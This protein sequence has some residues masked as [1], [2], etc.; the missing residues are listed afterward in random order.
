MN[1]QIIKNQAIGE[2]YI[3]ITH[4]TGLSIYL[5]Q[6]EGFSTTYAMFSTNY[7]SIDTKFKLCTDNEIHTVP[8]GIA[9]F[10]EHKLF[11]SEE[12]DVFM[13]FA[14]TGASANAF[15]SFEIT[16]YLFATT[17]NFNE[18]LEILLDFVQ[19]PYFTKESVEKEQGIIA[20]EIK[21]Y[22]DDPHWR[23]EFN[24]LRSMYFNHTVKE[25]VAGTVESISKITP[26][27]LYQCYKTFYNLNNMSL[28]IVGNFDINEVKSIIDNS[29]KP[30]EKVEINRYFENE[31][32]GVVNS[33]TQEE[34]PVSTPLFYFGY[35]ENILGTKND[36]EVAATEILLDIISSPS[37]PLYKK[38]YDMEL[39]ND[40]SFGCD[41]LEGEGYSAVLFE[42]ES[43]DSLKV[44]EEIK[45]YVS[46]L[47]KTG[48]DED[49]FRRAKKS[50][51]G[52]NISGL[53]S[54]SS[55][56]Y[57]ITSLSFK[58]RELYNYLSSF[59]DITLSDVE[60]RLHDIFKD[61][62]YVLSVINPQNEE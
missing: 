17:E 31:P 4:Q 2:E 42:G 9:H 3:K 49:D 35:K 39:I 48:I 54:V 32:D 46:K 59:A 60:K 16:S 34:L 21:M 57:T 38:L 22:D 10:L 50:I 28:T 5:Y 20:Q 1:E 13:K 62:N 43:K 36:K 56:A 19:S 30:C 8:S 47:K 33:F 52:T 18:S 29:L 55:I 6:K 51:Y 41:Y 14:Q 53:N 26:E 61:D 7:G 37:S 23:G 12:G 58:N 25:D 44:S 24:L 27:Y 15:T 40:A 11:E 45:A